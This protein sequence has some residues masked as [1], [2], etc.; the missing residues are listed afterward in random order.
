MPLACPAP[1]PP[2]RLG[3][4]MLTQHSP[5]SHPT[6]EDGCQL[7]LTHHTARP[8]RQDTAAHHRRAREQGCSRHRRQPVVRPRTW[9]WRALR[10][11]DAS[12]WSAWAA[13]ASTRRHTP[14]AAPCSAS[15]SQ[16]SPAEGGTGPSQGHPRTSCRAGG[17]T[18]A[19]RSPPPPPHHPGK[20]GNPQP[21]PQAAGQGYSGYRTPT[22]A[23]RVG[24]MPR[25]AGTPTSP[26]TGENGDTLSGRDT[27]PIAHRRGAGSKQP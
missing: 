20:A 25:R 11:R 1:P 16:H 15:G 12:P 18:A 10:E 24:R 6:T 26:G 21:L 2:E 14:H 4:S 22:P 5:S 3:P 27:P 9:G 17:R 7:P 19:S 23:V 13:T 8:S